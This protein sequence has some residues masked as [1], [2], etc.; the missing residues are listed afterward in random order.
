MFTIPREDRR[1]GATYHNPDFEPLET[2]EVV[3]LG[4]DEIDR[5]E[6]LNAE[7]SLP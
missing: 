5:F 4:F 6:E 2:A 7:E 3:F 1:M